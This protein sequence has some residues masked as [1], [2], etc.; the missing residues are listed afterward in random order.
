MP[1]MALTILALASLAQRQSGA[2]V[3]RRSRSRYPQ[4][5]RG[6]DM[7]TGFTTGFYPLLTGILPA[8]GIPF[9]YCAVM[10]PMPSSPNKIAYWE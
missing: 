2:L 4:E 7:G 1:D 9:S 8:Q 6:E 3:K 10:V 5:A